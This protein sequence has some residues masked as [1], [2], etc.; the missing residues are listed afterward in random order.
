[1]TKKEIEE[2]LEGINTE[3]EAENFK[4]KAINDD[5]IR[6][7]ITADAERCLSSR[8]NGIVE[9]IKKLNNGK[10]IIVFRY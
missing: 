9:G 8:R 2:K 10:T 1:M 5:S 6:I 7:R 4:T 3:E